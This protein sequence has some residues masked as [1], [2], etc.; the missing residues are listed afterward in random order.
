MIILYKEN[1]SYKTIIKKSKIIEQKNQTN[2]NTLIKTRNI[3]N[4]FKLKKNNKN[5][6]INYNFLIYILFHKKNKNLKKRNIIQLK[7][8]QIK[9]KKKD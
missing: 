9:N 8:Y 7:K 1:M 2:L 6:K 5:K 4:N 3:F